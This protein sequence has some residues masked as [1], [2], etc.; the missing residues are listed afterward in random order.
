M[1]SLLV[2]YTQKV[3]SYHKPPSRGTISH[4]ERMQGPHAPNMGYL[5]MEHETHANEYIVDSD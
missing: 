4:V 3:S 5:F 1:G 2:L